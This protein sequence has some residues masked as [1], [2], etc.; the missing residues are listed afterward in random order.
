[1]LHSEAPEPDTLAFKLPRLE[2]GSYR[3]EWK[4]LSVD[5]HFTQGVVTFTIGSGAGSTR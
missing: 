5:G 3:A 1:L 2:P 4:V